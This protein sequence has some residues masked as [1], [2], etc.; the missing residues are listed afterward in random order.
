MKRSSDTGFPPVPLLCRVPLFK[1]SSG[2]SSLQLPFI[3]LSDSSYCLPQRIRSTVLMIWMRSLVL[4]KYDHGPLARIFRI[5]QVPVVTGI[6]G[7][8]RHIIGIRSDDGKVC[9]IQALHIFI[10][11]HRQSP[12]RTRHP[13]PAQQSY[14][15]YSDPYPESISLRSA[16]ELCSISSL[17]SLC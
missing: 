8:D 5:V 9:R 7:H 6:S 1:L 11:E 3:V 12:F 17:W 13:A 16:P 4:M 15:L 2:R 14:P 10:T